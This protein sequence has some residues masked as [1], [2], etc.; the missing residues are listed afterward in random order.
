MSMQWVTLRQAQEEAA[1]TVVVKQHW[2]L[3]EDRTRVVE[4]GHP[5]GRWLWASPGTAVRLAE[6][7]QLGAVKVEPEAEVVEPESEPADELKA[8]EKAEEKPEEKAVKPAANKAAKKSP[9]KAE[10][11]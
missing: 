6:A 3:T 2:Y 10:G 11:K 1:G 9:N 5:D 7:I 4:E 8:D